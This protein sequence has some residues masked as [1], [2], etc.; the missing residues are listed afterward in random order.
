M[1]ICRDNSCMK[2]IPPLVVLALST[3]VAAAPLVAVD[4]GH[5]I[6]DSGAISARGRTEFAFNRDFA[7]LLAT[8]LRQRELGV[9]EV[10]FDGRIGSLHARPQAA[11]G[12]D[13]FISIHHDSIGEAWL[14][15]DPAA[16]QARTRPPLDS[17][18]TA[19]WPRPRTL[20]AAAARAGPPG[21]RTPTT[22]TIRTGQH[23]CVTTDT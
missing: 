13:F 8:T 22:R 4:V 1:L 15:D 23:C 5:G 6:Q 14:L 2:T 3:T 20:S 10:N 17:C 12:S 16:A 9:R 11:E 19:R 21:Y 7:G 18:R